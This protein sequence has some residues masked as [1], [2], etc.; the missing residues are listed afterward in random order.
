MEDLKKQ[1]NPCYPSLLQ[2]FA[3]G[4]IQRRILYIDVD[5]DWNNPFNTI[6]AAIDAGF[7]VILFAFYLN[8]GPTDMLAAFASMSATQQAQAFAYAAEKKAILG[9][10]A[11][12]ATEIPYVLNPVTY[13][14][15]LA[16][17]ALKNKF[18]IVDCD[19]ENIAPEF[20]YPGVPNLYTWFK[21]FNTTLLSKLGSNALVSAVPELPFACPL[22]FPQSWP[23]KGGGM[24]G[25][26][27]NNPEI[28]WLSFQTY[29]QNSYSSYPTTFVKADPNMY[30]GSSLG[31]ISESD[32]KNG[33]PWHKII[34]ATY[35]QNNDANNGEHTPS[36][37]KSWFAEA[38]QQFGYDK[39]I[40]V[41]QYHNSGTI[42][43]SQFIQQLYG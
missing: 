19:F 2:K 42:L 16:T 36:V 11:G 12:G 1:I 30:P 33:I 31:E 5:I 22:N 34:F 14:E 13:A 17:Y 8:S 41:W 25:V 23:G 40:A 32:N 21:S 9:F 43:P 27:L 4:Q 24:L 10:S 18:Q 35:L 3:L 37:L 15:T 38:N 20:S 39:S 28:A 6:K 7:N 29:N 26:Y